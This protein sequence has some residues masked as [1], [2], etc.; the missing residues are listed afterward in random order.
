MTYRN[1][2]EVAEAVHDGRVNHLHHFDIGRSLESQIEEWVDADYSG[3]YA[4]D[5]RMWFCL[6]VWESMK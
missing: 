4:N 3:F 1:L 2:L 6:F 5:Q